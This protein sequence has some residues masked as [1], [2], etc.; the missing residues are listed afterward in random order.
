MPVKDRPGWPFVADMMGGGPGQ[1]R[2]RGEADRPSSTPGKCFNEQLC[3][4]RLQADSRLLMAVDDLAMQIAMG[5]MSVEGGRV[6][7]TKTAG[8]LTS[9]VSCVL[10]LEWVSSANVFAL[11]LGSWHV[12]KE[13]GPTA[14]IPGPGAGLPTPTPVGAIRL[15]CSDNTLVQDRIMGFTR[16]E[17]FLLLQQV[18]AD[19]LP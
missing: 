14:Q 4:C 11:W 8:L 19:G 1:S 13:H 2:P 16:S 10:H 12:K 18:K 7:G 3:C 6:Y 5:W 17:V 9:T 15:P